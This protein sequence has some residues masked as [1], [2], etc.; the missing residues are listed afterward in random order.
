MKSI[1][2]T[3]LATA[4]RRGMVD[5]KGNTV[6]HSYLETPIEATLAYLS[7]TNYVRF[8]IVD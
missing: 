4:R 7:E 1:V 2:A 3:S 6:V 8:G 5:G